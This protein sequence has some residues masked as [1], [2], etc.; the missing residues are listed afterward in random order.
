MRRPGC[1]RLVFVGCKSSWPYAYAYNWLGTAFGL[2]SAFGRDM[3]GDGFLG[4]GGSAN[5]WSTP[6]DNLALPESR[7]LVPSDMIAIGDGVRLD[8][9]LWGIAGFGWPG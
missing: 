9:E 5:G 1:A 8:F 3:V 6:P 4:L 2:G 7:V